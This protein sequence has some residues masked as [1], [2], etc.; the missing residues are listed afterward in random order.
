M[1]LAARGGML[2]RGAELGGHGIVDLRIKADR[3]ERIAGYLQR[4]PDEALI[5][6]DG[7]ALLPGLHDHHLHLYSLAASL[8]S[9]DCGP[10]RVREAAQLA[11]ILADAAAE[12]APG[13]WLRGVGYH[14][15]VAGELTRD[16]LD[17]WV[18]DFPLRIQH[19]SGR[20]WIFNS[21]GLR[22]LGL[23][24]ARRG[25]DPFERLGQRR[26]GRLYDADEWLRKQLKHTAPGLGPI[27][28]LLAR[29]GITGLTDAT[30]SNTA[31]SLAAFESA[32]AEGALLQAIRVMGDASLDEAADGDRVTRGEHKFH[33]HAHE[34]PELGSLVAAIRR[35]HRHRRRVAFH[36]VTRTELVFAL[37]ALEMAGPLRGD[38]IEH[39]SIAPDELL[40]QMRQLGI[41]VVTQPGFIATRGDVYRR[42]VDPQ[43]QPWLYRLRGLVDA[44]I[45]L[46][47]SSDAPFGDLNPWAAMQAA[48]DR[49]CE[50]GVLLGVDEGLSPEQALALFTSSAHAPGRE[51]RRVALGEPA[52]LCLRSQ[53]W[54]HARKALGQVRVRATLQ[55]GRAIWNGD[56]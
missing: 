19:R 20:L 50:S 10:P 38:R 45:P 54:A 14:S 15:S 4:R 53:P 17:R 23:D 34:L 36:C 29:Y 39:A 8:E 2:I 52:D 9:I 49:K 3:I 21:A 35:S 56:I 16:E 1:D 26:S 24:D 30:P 12:R 7:G 51:W 41:S 33:L 32:C 43:E 11:R 48:V 47:G 31:A 27:S 44:G 46:A 18:A 13:Q 40:P 25:D 22:A 42:E 37:A 28:R 55:A 5:E 6:A